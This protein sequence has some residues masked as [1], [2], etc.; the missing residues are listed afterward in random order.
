MKDRPGGNAVWSD[1]HG[2]V[3]RD[4]ADVFAG[5]AAGVAAPAFRSTTWGRWTEALAAIDG[6]LLVT[7]EYEHL[8]VALK[9]DRDRTSVSY[10]HLPHPS[11]IAVDAPKGRVHVACSRNPNQ[12]VSLTQ[13]RSPAASGPVLLPET[14][15]FFPGRLYMHDLA[16]VGGRLHAAA[17]G[18]NAIV[19]LDAGGAVP[20]WWPKTASFRGRLR[21]DKNYLQ[22]NSIAAG[23]TLA[24]S[25]FTASTERA[26]RRRP[27]H[28]NFAVD[29]RGVLF[30]GRTG[31]PEVRGLTRPHSATMHWNKVWLDNS[32]YGEVGLVDRGRFEVVARLPGWTRGLAFEGGYA[33]VGVSRVLPR[34][35]AYA[36]GLD[37]RRCRCGIEVVELR[38]GTVVGGLSWPSGNQI[39]AIAILPAKLGRL[40]YLVERNAEATRRA[41]AY[42]FVRTTPT[43]GK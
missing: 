1:W 8:L 19:R 7:R 32:G 24:D 25:Y 37:P 20:K 4:P 31:E 11:G 12:V 14:T 28:R 43:R 2:E 33:F 23:A 38:T 13:A 21:S 30:S 39:F 40:P 3:L 5:V 22:L 10:I 9:A 27:G 42:D 17:P 16:F 34:Y 15:E 26:G 36:P 6:S 18:I 41:L 35:E 29:K